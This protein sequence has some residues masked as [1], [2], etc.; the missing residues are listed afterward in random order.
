V[1]LSPTKSVLVFGEKYDTRLMRKLLLISI[2]G[3]A[4]YFAYNHW[5]AAPPPPPPPPPIVAQK[6]S[7][8]LKKSV[9]HLFEEWQ[10]RKLSPHVPNVAAIIPEQELARIR[11]TLFSDGVYSEQAFR[12]AVASALLELGVSQAEVDQIASEVVSLRSEQQKKASGHDAS[13]LGGR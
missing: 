11:N 13:S 2:L 7:L 4:S 9:R 8:G 1:F 6:V 10:R 12:A 5:F 3:L